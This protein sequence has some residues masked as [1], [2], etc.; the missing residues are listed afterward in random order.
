MS[1]RWTSREDAILVEFFDAVSAVELFSHMDRSANAIIERVRHLKA[2]GAWAAYKE[3]S[4]H[5]FHARLLA[6]GLSDD[7]IGAHEAEFAAIRAR[8]WTLP[9]GVPA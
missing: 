1:R 9:E 6:G 8:G 3:A 4:L 7:L 5:H 2:T